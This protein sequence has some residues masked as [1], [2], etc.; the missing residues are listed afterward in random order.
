MS[1]ADIIVNLDLHRA[2]FCARSES[3]NFRHR[4]RYVQ[5]FAQCKFLIVE[6]LTLVVRMTK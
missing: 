3:N 1:G 6:R 2:D 5:K 4:A